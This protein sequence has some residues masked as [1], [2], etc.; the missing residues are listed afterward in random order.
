MKV[1]IDSIE[2]SSVNRWNRI[3][4][5]IEFN[6]NA[7]V[8]QEFGLKEC[9][10]AFEADD[11]LNEIGWDEAEKYFSDEIQKIRAEV[12]KDRADEIAQLEARI[13]ELEA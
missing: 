2:I 7:E 12:E 3:E 5:E 9:L 13:A 1:L 11:F 4:A 8:L 6:D 10:N